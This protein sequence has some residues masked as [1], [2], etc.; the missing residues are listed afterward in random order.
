MQ[1]LITINLNSRL[2]QLDERGYDALRAYLAH[3]EAQL[4]ANPD[5]VE[6]VRDLEQSIADKFLKIGEPAR[7]IV[8]AADVD[9]VLREIG[10]VDAGV[11]GMGS[12]PASGAPG[13]APPASAP[14][15]LYRIREGAMITGLCNGIA[16]HFN[17]DPT[18]VR[19]AFVVAAIVEIASFDRPP[20]GVAGLYAILA[21][22]VPDATPA[23]QGAPGM[24]G[25]LIDKVR[26]KIQRVRTA[27]FGG[28][29][30]N[31]RSG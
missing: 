19:V 5:R 11:A 16:Q 26:F 14:R 15:R 31:A 22:I 12:V 13:I 21:L 7:A 2:F 23:T 6:I 8:T 28:V 1:K 9:D 18:F 10:P 30:H 20:A 24:P 3:A 17:I 4:G 25:S 27:V 29:G